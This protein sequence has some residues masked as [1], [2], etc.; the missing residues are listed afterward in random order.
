MPTA[1]V[2]SDSA[3]VPLDGKAP[4]QIIVTP[5]DVQDPE[6]LARQL[7]DA[8]NSIAELKRAWQPR[9]LYVRDVPVTTLGSYRFEH[10]FGGRVNW[11]VV[12]WVPDSSGNGFAF[13]LDPSSDDDTLVLFSGQDG[14]ATICIE[15][16][17]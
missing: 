12:M 6:K 10:R 14:T 13:E 3:M 2:T 9:R 8:L 17:D 15:E 11:W 16:A 4:S 7:Q 5:K 1:F